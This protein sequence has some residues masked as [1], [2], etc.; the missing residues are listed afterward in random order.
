MC[1]LLIKNKNKNTFLNNLQID[2]Q[3][4]ENIKVCKISTHG[5]Y[6]CLTPHCTEKYLSKMK[7][8]VC[9]VNMLTSQVLYC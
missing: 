8:N 1:R 3:H 6:S 7:V 5:L 2:M 9:I 4:K